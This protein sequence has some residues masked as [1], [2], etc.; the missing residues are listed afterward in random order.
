[1]RPQVDLA[2]RTSWEVAG[3]EDNGPEAPGA[4]VVAADTVE[5][6]PACCHQM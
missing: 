1:M 2:G 5:T 4:A 6:A 3:R